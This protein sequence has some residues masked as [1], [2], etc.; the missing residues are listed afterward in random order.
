MG[1]KGRGNDRGIAQKR[2]TVERSALE[3][4]QKSPTAVCSEDAV[5]TA[6]GRIGMS[7][8]LVPA[9]VGMETA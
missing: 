5:Q 1:V 3:T 7:G 8:R 6:L 9:V 2:S 4:R